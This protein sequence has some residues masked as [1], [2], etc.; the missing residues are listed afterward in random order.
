V[1][2]QE[3]FLKAFNDLLDMVESDIEQDD[4]CADNAERLGKV[5]GNRKAELAGKLRDAR[6]LRRQRGGSDGQEGG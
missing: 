5:T 2:G 4:L 6:L 1:L 3:A